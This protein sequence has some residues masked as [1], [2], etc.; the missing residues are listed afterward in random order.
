MVASSESIVTAEEVEKSL[1][2]K[3]DTKK[4]IWTSKEGVQ[5]RD[6]GIAPGN[7]EFV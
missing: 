3:L 4:G 2:T 5:V 1:D 7:D 6:N